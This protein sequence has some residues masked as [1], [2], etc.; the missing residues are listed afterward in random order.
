[1][2]PDVLEKFSKDVKW[3]L[4]ELKQE[5]LANAFSDYKLSFLVEQ[6]SDKE[7][8]T[9]SQNRILKMLSDRKMITLSPFYH[10]TNS[11]FSMALEMQGASPI[12][13]YIKILQPQFDEAYEETLKQKTFILSDPSKEKPN[14]TQ[15]QSENMYSITIRDKAVLL[16]NTFVLS[17][18]NFDSENNNFIDYIMNNQNKTLKKD[19]IEK[20][21][22]RKIKKSF[23]SIVN[24]L[25]FKGEIRKIFFKVSK[26][27]VFFNNNIPESKFEDIGI[28][29]EKLVRELSLLDRK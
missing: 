19:F 18:P 22:G 10:P 9:R 25:G 21:L 15:K 29:K 13:Y 11:M 23:H 14:P 27:S 5:E 7:P 6:K 1:M 2:T 3:V 28:N 20:E 16:N 26:V 17:T 12:G 8:D 4:D 24:D